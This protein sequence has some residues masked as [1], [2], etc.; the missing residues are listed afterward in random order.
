MEPSSAMPLT[1]RNNN[2]HESPSEWLAW[3]DLI[4]DKKQYIDE[5][6]PDCQSW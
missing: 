5:K 2:A 6:D 3:A 4:A 1:G